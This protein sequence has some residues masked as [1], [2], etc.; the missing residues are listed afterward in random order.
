MD[1]L[2]SLPNQLTAARLVLVVL[3]WGFALAGEA[4]AVG[5]GLALAFVT[6]VADGAAARRLGRVTA[7]GSRFDSIVDSVIGPSAVAWLLL[8]RPEVIT[9]H[10]VLAATWLLTTYASLAVGLLRHRRFAN[11][12]LRSS[13]VACIAQYA[14]LVDAFV[15][16][17]Y[18]PP[19]LFL[20]AGL[21]IYASLETLVLQLAL[22]GVDEHE[23]SLVHG[24]R[25][26]RPA[27]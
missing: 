19:L 20:A 14:F 9:G 4:T 24:L 27:L 11:L 22:D 21:G 6:D 1:R 8:L 7:F 25:R 18:S 17:S 13:R 3:S 12:H 23:R 5:V 16:S 10:V 2:R 26:R 15:T